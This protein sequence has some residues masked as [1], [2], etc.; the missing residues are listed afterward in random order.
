MTQPLHDQKRA[1]AG[2]GVP[3]SASSTRT[4]LDDAAL[5]ERH[6]M[7]RAR[8]KALGKSRTAG[9][10]A[11][12]LSK[13]AS[14]GVL[15]ANAK[16]IAACTE[17]RKWKITGVPGL[18]LQV[19]SPTQR[20]WLLRYRFCGVN[21][22]KGLG[23]LKEVGLTEA[24]NRV[25]AIRAEIAQGRDPLAAAI[26]T[27]LEVRTFRE[28]A[29]DFIKRKEPEWKDPKSVL[30]WKGTLSTHAYP[31]IG[32]RPCSEITTAEILAVLQPIWKTKTETAKRVQG[33]IRDVLA[34][35]FVLSQRR[36]R[37][38]HNPATWDGNLKHLLPAPSK[39]RKTEHYAA[40]NWRDAPA[41]FAKI[42]SA[43][44]S[45]ALALRFTVM[46]AARTKMTRLAQWHEIDHD[47]MTWS[48]PPERMLEA[49]EAVLSGTKGNTVLVPLSSAVAAI[50]VEAQQMK[51]VD[52]FI[53]PGAKIA[54]PLSENTLLMAARRQGV[55]A[56]VHGW[57]STFSTW[58]KEWLGGDLEETEV[59][60]G[61]II[62]GVRGD[63]MRGELL[64]HRRLMMEAWAAFLLRTRDEAEQARIAYRTFTL[65]MAR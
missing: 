5:A 42:A 53:F 65:T 2:A 37:D 25:A 13:Q 18:Y 7:L 27:P 41:A 45:G 40:V 24:R 33:R 47:E 61:H 36:W 49:G 3:A 20:S 58:S 55:N 39:I 34:A 60:L 30:A 14:K 51:R 38:W 10:A 15:P 35:E 4:K 16:A 43:T 12:P 52:D 19:N 31:Q 8:K 22:E 11:A 21:R 6:K 28:A 29:E 32:A 26:V 48:V 64:A 50:L 54:K 57:R 23:S 63:Y 17:M 56:T 46:T 1:L 62:P 44:G 9:N 59:A